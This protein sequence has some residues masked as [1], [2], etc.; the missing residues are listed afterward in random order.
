MALVWNTI[1]ADYGS[2]DWLRR[3]LCIKVGYNPDHR[4]LN[5]AERSYI[6]SLIESGVMQ[7]CNAAYPSAPMLPESIAGEGRSIDSLQQ[8]GEKEAKR[9]PPH[10]WSFLHKIYDISISAGTS[11]YEL[12]Q[13]F[14][15]WIGEPTTVRAGGKIAIV[16]DSH[17]RQLQISYSKS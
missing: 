2:F 14:G 17:I 3:E 8:E 7:F 11:N 15:A 9:K 1:D 5:R 10:N 12:P 6:D 13:D 16:R 4:L